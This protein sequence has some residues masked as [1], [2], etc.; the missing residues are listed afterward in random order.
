MRHWHHRPWTGRE[1]WFTEDRGGGSGPDGAVWY[2]GV[3]ARADLG[4]P[5]N[6][7][8]RITTDGTITELELPGNAAAM[9]AGG[10]AIWIAGQG[11]VWRV[12]LQGSNS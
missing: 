7:L 12:N 4:T 5:V 1:P 10:G 3:P 6:R 11:Q 2:T 8:Y 9:A